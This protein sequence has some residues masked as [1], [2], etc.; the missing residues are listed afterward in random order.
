VNIG[1]WSHPIIIRCYIKQNG[2]NDYVFLG[3]S[4]A[5]FRANCY[6]NPRPVF[7]T[8]ASW[9]MLL[10]PSRYCFSSVNA[11]MPQ[12]SHDN[13]TTTNDLKPLSA[14][15]T[16]PWVILLARALSS[17]GFGLVNSFIY[18]TSKDNTNL[19]FLECICHVVAMVGA[20]CDTHSS[21]SDFRVQDEQ[22]PDPPTVFGAV[23]GQIH[24]TYST[25][26]FSN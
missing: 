20:I 6:T 17:L 25:E 3:L 5:I 7:Y 4:Y 16:S 11:P 9:S 2:H 24:P 14:N 23:T 10:C 13:D 21:P 15:Q 12:T 18:H 26:H 1:K 8:L 22:P 19:C